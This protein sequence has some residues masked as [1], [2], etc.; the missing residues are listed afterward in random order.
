RSP[1][2][3]S[4]A[5]RSRAIGHGWAPRA[6]AS[7]WPYRAP[8]TAPPSG[9]AP[10]FRQAGPPRSASAETDRAHACCRSRGRV[11]RTLTRAV[12]VAGEFAKLLFPPRHVLNPGLIARNGLLEA[13]LFSFE[14]FDVCLRLAQ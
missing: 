10:C 5:R 4:P 14:N 8:E 3:A 1:G 13:R 9:V 2:R 12:V 6:R 7:G 11:S